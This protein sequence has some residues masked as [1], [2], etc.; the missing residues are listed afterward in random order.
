MK[1]RVVGVWV[2][3]GG[4]EGVWVWHRVM[5]RTL[6]SLLRRGTTPMYFPL[7]LSSFQK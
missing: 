3:V 7:Q 4:G 5:G 2:G 1:R 6:S